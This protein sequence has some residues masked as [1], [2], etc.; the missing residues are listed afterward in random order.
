VPFD[1]LIGWSQQPEACLYQEAQ[2][3]PTQNPAAGGDADQPIAWRG[4]PQD[5]PVRSEG[6]QV[7]K[8]FDLLGSDDEDIFHGIV[9]QLRSPSR[10]VFVPADDVTLMTA[11]HVDVSLTAGELAALPAHTEE[12]EFEVGMVGHLRKHLGWVREKDR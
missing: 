7:G 8:L 12:R 9:V 3:D 5:T 11:T 6:Q 4:V 1:S 10:R 2:V